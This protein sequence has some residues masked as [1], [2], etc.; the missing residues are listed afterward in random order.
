VNR[1]ALFALVLIAAG[2]GQHERTVPADAVALV[3]TQQIS[4]AEFDA[5]LARAKRA[6]VARGEAFPKPGTG[7]YRRVRDSVVALLVDRAR[8]EI[9]ARRAHVAVTAEQVDVRL[10]EFKRR[11]FGG[12]EQR[13][14]EQLERTGLT[15]ADVRA[16]I[17]T[18]LL[19]EKL[20][21]TRS[22]PPEVTYAPGFE[23]PDGQ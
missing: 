10:R 1:A 8:L 9:E 15:E 7:A 11:T 5:E 16:A 21:A 3:G 13:F 23:P 4:R 19:E 17:R 18:E 22:A 20:G 12:D 2:C 6:Y 14:R